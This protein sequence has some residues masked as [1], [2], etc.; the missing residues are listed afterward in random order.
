MIKPTTKN[1]VNNCFRRIVILTNYRER[2]EAELR[3]R[4]VNKEKFS[5]DIFLEA[6]DKA[7]KY[8]IV[9]DERYAEI[10]TFCKTQS[11]RG[12]DGIEKHLKCMKINYEAIPSVVDILNN[13]KAEEFK[14][15]VNYLKNHPSRAKNAYASNVRKLI[16]RGFST[17][18]AI[19]AAKDLL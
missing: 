18:L 11:C 19:S 6:I 15:A 16:S 5:E 8:D 14:S 12:I 7:K 10:Y 13:A 2:C 1:E 3:D 17:S 9:N 4:L